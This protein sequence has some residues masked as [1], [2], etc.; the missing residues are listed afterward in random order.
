LSPITAEQSNLLSGEPSSGKTTFAFD[1]AWKNAEMGHRVLYLSLEMS[2]KEIQSRLA[3]AYAGITKP[4]WRDR[5]SISDVKRAAF[6]KRIDELKRLKTLILSGMPEGVAPTIENIFKM[7]K[8]SGADIAFIDNF[9]LIQKNAGRSNYDEENRIS[10]M[11]KDF[12]KKEQIPLIILHHKSKLKTSGLGGI[13]GSG[14]IVDDRYTALGCEREYA[15]DGT[16][17]ENAKFMVIEMKDRDFGH[18]KVN[19]VYFKR[20]SF[21]DSYEDRL[22]PSVPNWND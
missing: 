2:R 8:G 3:R 14:K 19:V 1:I 20:G 12:P 7:I 21:Y 17:E 13:R 9:D 16:D 22:P 18:R 11:L 15:E 10:A 4:E 6:K 5:T